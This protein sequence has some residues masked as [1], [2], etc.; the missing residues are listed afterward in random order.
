MFKIKDILHDALM[1]LEFDELRKALPVKKSDFAKIEIMEPIQDIVRTPEDN[2]YQHGGSIR[3]LEITAPDQ[4]LQMIV[5]KHAYV[6]ETK[7]QERIT[8]T[9]I[10][11]VTVARQL[12]G[13][14]RLEAI[15]FAKPTR[16]KYPEA[17]VGLVKDIIR[18]GSE[19]SQV[20]NLI[21]IALSSFHILFKA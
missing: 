5:F 13:N 1:N 15:G 21:Y 4:C 18:H 11:V 19:P 8:M 20:N 14:S 12:G 7:F 10:V 6:T 2:G 17:A 16:V 3:R 9:P